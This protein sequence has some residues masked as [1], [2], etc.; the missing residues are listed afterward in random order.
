MAPMLAPMRR[1]LTRSVGPRAAMAVVLAGTLGVT[2]L[3]VAGPGT[4]A[5]PDPA[6]GA[7][8]DEPAPVAPTITYV[9]D[10]PPDE[11]DDDLPPWYRAPVTFRFTCADADSV[12]AI[13]PIPATF[14]EDGRGLVT[15][16]AALDAEGHSTIA[17]TPP[18]N[19]DQTPPDVMLVGVADGAVLPAHPTVTCEASDALSGVLRAC[20]VGGAAPLGGGWYSVTVEARDRAGNVARSTARYQLE[21]APPDGLVAVVQSTGSA[22]ITEVFLG[23]DVSP[24]DGV[25]ELDRSLTAPARPARPDHLGT[26]V[27]PG[28]GEVGGATPLAEDQLAC[29]A[30]LDPLVTG[31]VLVAD[32]VA[33]NGTGFGGELTAAATGPIEAG[34]FIPFSGE[35]GDLGAVIA[36]SVSFVAAADSPCG[37]PVPPVF[38]VPLADAVAGGRA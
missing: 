36:G 1:L 18:I 8:V 11:A 3:A 14:T 34:T 4:G 23:F 25:R 10:R 17:I 33:S 29:S 35:I 9:V 13:C 22:P 24:A 6:D 21:P 30:P 28:V 12:V 2:V 32:F 38:E 27:V 7:A 31:T 20:A 16:V 15:A 19:L 37:P 26:F 5:T